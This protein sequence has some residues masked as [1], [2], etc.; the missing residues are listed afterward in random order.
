MTRAGERMDPDL[1][2]FDSFHVVM[3]HPLMTSEQWLSAYN[4]AWE[5]FYSFENIRNILMRA[6]EKLYWN[7]FKNYMWYKNSLLEPRHPMVA[8][9]VRRKHRKDVRP[10]IPI[11]GFWKF[12]AR[13]AKELF[14]GFRRRISLF[15]E[16]EELW[17]LTRNPQDPTFRFVADFAAAVNE[18]KHRIAALD[19]RRQY[20]K[21]REEINA[22]RVR[23]LEKIHHHSQNA[24][25][26]GRLRRRYEA[27]IE[28]MSAQ[29][30]KIAQNEQYTRGVSH[31][32]AYL[33]KTVQVVEEI[34]LKQVKRRR[35]ITRYWKLAKSRIREGKVFRFLLS[36]PKL[37]LNGLKDIRMSMYFLFHLLNGGFSRHHK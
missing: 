7:V 20:S 22:A 33:N 1:N 31:I 25:I 29:M 13:R 17:F 24:D 32:T 18:T 19:F 21:L 15:L 12:Q 37:T 4:E 14:G 10:G 30:E 27:L 2:K 8:G 23:M 11:M 26:S 36:A 9:F 16:M 34:S 5:S 3:D 6:G 28:D 35:K